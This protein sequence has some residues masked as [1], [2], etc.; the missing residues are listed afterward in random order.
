MTVRCTRRGSL[1]LAL[2]LAAGL[3]PRWSAAAGAT[4]P[5][6][7][8]ANVLRQPVNLAEYWVSEKLDGVRGYWDGERLLTRGRHPIAAPLWFTAGWPRQALDGELWAGRGRFEH[9]ASTV[10]TAVP[11][12]AA[13]RE[14]RFMVF[15][16]PSHA[17]RFDERLAALNELI[18]ALKR[19][20]VQPVPQRKLADHA[21]L[22][23]LLNRTVRGGGEGLMLHRGDSFYRGVRSDD[24]LKLKPFD[25]AEATVLAHL[26][27]NGRHAGRV[28]ALLVQTPEGL[29]FRL[30]SGLS[31]ALRSDPP[32]VGSCVTYRHHGL[33]DSGL[34]RFASFLRLRKD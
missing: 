17:G 14:M 32:P 28:G 30:G 27:G 22:Q 5:S 9:A 13:W 4:P 26:P 11:D 23:A 25:D 24:L 8:L 6:L 12:D 29:R 16:L 10:A 31:D 18:A 3:L 21:A 34:P 20:W 2:T 7:M 19:P 15:D 33:H 1:T